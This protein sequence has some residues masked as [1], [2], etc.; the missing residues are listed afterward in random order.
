ME[1]S[2]SSVAAAINALPHLLDPDG[3]LIPQML[4]VL[5]A[6]IIF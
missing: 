5:A 2:G 4:Q 3:T 6:S 1:G